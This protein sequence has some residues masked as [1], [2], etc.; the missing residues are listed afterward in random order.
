MYTYDWKIRPVFFWFTVVHFSGSS[1]S[2]RVPNFL[3]WQIAMSMVKDQTDCSQTTKTSTTRVSRRKHWSEWG[4]DDRF[5]CKKMENE[6]ER[7]REKQRQR[8]R[9]KQKV[10]IPCDLFWYFFRLSRW[11]GA[12]TQ[13]CWQTMDSQLG[14]F[15]RTWPQI[16][17]DLIRNKGESF[18]CTTKLVVL[19]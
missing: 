12:D 8:Q 15:G 13:Q 3:V 17:L 19:N 18:F 11:E 4:M 9:D 16:F 1:P 10:H 6:R 5:V 2:A 14:V 7:E